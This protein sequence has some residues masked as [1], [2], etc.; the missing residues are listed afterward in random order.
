MV[1]E[2]DLIEIIEIQLL[3]EVGNTTTK[4]EEL[5]TSHHWK[6]S[7]KDNEKE[8]EEEKECEEEE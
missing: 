1:K 4:E 6:G 8:G 5:D 7:G 2:E 3:E